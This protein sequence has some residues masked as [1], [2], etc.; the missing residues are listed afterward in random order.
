MHILRWFCYVPIR[1]SSIFVAHKYLSS[2]L[3]VFSSGSPSRMRKVRRISF[4]MTIL[5]RSST[6]LTIPVA[7]I[8]LLSLWLSN[9]SASICKTRGFILRKGPIFTEGGSEMK[10]NTKKTGPSGGRSFTF[11]LCAK[12]GSQAAGFQ[13][14]IQGV[15]DGGDNHIAV[16]QQGAAAA[17]FSDDTDG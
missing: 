10:M 4:G 5:P 8:Y 17:L 3:N 12:S 16:H 15:I 11:V 9:N 1:C 7:F 6:R 13:Q 2:T 14:Q